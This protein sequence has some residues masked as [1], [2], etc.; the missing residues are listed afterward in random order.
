MSHGQAV[1]SSAE[2][3]RARGV[4]M[5]VAVPSGAGRTRAEGLTAAEVRA[6]VERGQT[7]AVPQRT[8]RTVGDIVRA[9]LL[10]RFNVILVILLAAIL[11][12]GDYRDSLF[13][14]VPTVNALIGIVQELR[15]RRTLERLALLHAPHATV[16]RDGAGSVVA[17][18]DVVLD[19]ILEVA[20]G[21]QVVA[22]GVVT[23]STGLQ[24]DESLISGEADPVDKQ[25][26]DRVLSGSFAVAGRGRFQA[27]AVGAGAYAHGL[28]AEARTYTVV[29]SDL[30][31][32][33]NRI[34]QY[35]TY[36]L[37]PT[38]ALLILSQIDTG[39]GVRDTVSGVVAALT[40]MVPQGLVLLTSIAFTVAALNLAR[41]QALVQELPAVEGLARVDVL[42][43]DKTGTLTDGSIRFAGVEPLA[44]DMPVETAL[45]ALASA[46]NP[47]ATLSAIASAYPQDPGWRRTGEVAFSSAR[48]WSAAAFDGHGT[49]VI[50]A[51]EMVMARG[52]DTTALARAAELAA[53]GRRVLLLGCT[54]APLQ[55]NDLPDGIRAAAL[56]LLE[57]HLRDDAADTIAYFAA[58]GVAIKLI[59]GDSP[60]TLAVIAEQ[61]HID[62]AGDAV[63]ARQ[64]DGDAAALGSA[65]EAHT[66]FG[67][68]MPRQKQEMVRALQAGGHTVAMTGDGVNDVL[69]LK[70]ADIGIAMGSGAPATR[71]VAQL[72]LLDGRFAS[73][74]G[75]VAEGRRVAANVERVAN[76]FVTKSVWATLLAVSIALARW[77]Y[78]FLPRHISIIDTLTIGVPAFFLAVVPNPR[79][80]IP[81]FVDRV[82]HFT[83]PVGFLVA[84]TAFIAYALARGADVPLIQQRTAATI[85]TLAMSLGVLVLLTPPW[86]VVR[87]L[88]V[89]GVWAAFVTLFVVEPLRHF[90]A[91]EVPRSVLL[92]IVVVAVVGLAFL[93]GGWAISRRLGRGP[94]AAV[95]RGR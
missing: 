43:M 5:A 17:V 11:A 24:V 44:D 70:S 30:R 74:P 92:P 90:L 82:L 86:T 36:A 4:T 53:G 38:G 31:D 78:P 60:R 67:R 20:S 76:L 6:R 65:L 22:D 13:G 51:P 73:L 94:A 27:T 52:D 3:T 42:C 2:A 1:R 80:Y 46:T 14:I 77:P 12:V 34:L 16:V 57:E 93:T 37:V 58:Q 7:N 18:D 40:A 64:L 25:P 9:N 49:W 62:G 79:R 95:D 89:A 68:V 75:A 39:V 55:G 88:L 71:A 23:D 32:G 54:D 66:L 61:V 84:A 69:A 48:K 45:A 56:V 19:D 87:I 28:A 63:D 21:D 35:A 15:A 41:R 10:T 91:L 83:I 59:S 81:G 33:I 72:V 50:G 85:V 26:G 47:N 29:H 8:S